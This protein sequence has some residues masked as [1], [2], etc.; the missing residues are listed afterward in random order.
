MSTLKRTRAGSEDYLSRSPSPSTL[1]N[2][3]IRREHSRAIAERPAAD[4]LSDNSHGLDA[5]PSTSRAK[6]PKYRGLYFQ[7]SSPGQRMSPPRRK[8]DTYSSDAG[9]SSGSNHHHSSRSNS[10][11]K[12]YSHRGTRPALP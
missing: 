11:Y 6:F 10:L 1:P 7:A 3:R 9:H 12:G 5:Y 4:A 8:P 2:K